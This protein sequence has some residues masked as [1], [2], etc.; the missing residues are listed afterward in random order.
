[1]ITCTCQQP[2]AV[3]SIGPKETAGLI[4]SDLYCNRCGYPLGNDDR[5]IPLIQRIGL[6]LWRLYA[7]EVPDWDQLEQLLFKDPPELPWEQW[8]RQQRWLAGFGFVLSMAMVALAVANIM[9][10]GPTLLRTFLIGF[11]L[12][13]L[14]VQIWFVIWQNRRLRRLT[15]RLG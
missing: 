6:E 11:G 9:N 10:W 5:R 8:Q 12:G 1:M 15:G 4:P 14:G 2:Y 13:A 3:N 7:T